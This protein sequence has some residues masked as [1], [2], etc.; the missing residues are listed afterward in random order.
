MISGEAK[1]VVFATG[2]HTGFGRIAH[3]AQT[4]AEEIS[5]PLRRQVAAAFAARIRPLERL[6]DPAVKMLLEWTLSTVM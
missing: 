5:S 4:T 3:L 2:M 6:Y 1:A